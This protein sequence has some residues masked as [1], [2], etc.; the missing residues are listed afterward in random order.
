MPNMLKTLVISSCT[1]EKRFHPENQLVQDDFRDA[2][3]LRAREKK[4][5]EFLLPAGEMYTS[6]QHLRLMEGVAALR[7]AGI[8]VDLAIVSAGYGLIPETRKIAPYEVTFNSMKGPEIDEW[9]IRLGIHDSLVRTLA[10]YD[11]VFFLLG[12]KYLRAA[13]LR[14]YHPR[15][16]QT[17]LFFAS[18]ASRKS[19]P[20]GAGIASVELGNA[21]ARRFGYGLVGLKGELFRRLAV[22]ATQDGSLF[23]RLHDAPT[24]F[25]E[26]LD[27]VCLPAG[28]S[29]SA[30]SQPLLFELPEP[31]E[32]PKR[33]S[34]KPASPS[35]LIPHSEWAAN[36]L[37]HMKYFIP[38]WD[39]LV[40]PNYDF[41]TDTP[42][43]N[44]DPYRDD[45][46]A[47]EIYDRPNYDGILVSKVIVEA[48]KRK[49]TLMKQTD[50]QKGLR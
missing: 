38:E 31:V 47:H 5:A 42:T 16:D 15:Q 6:M 44:H 37:P 23:T 1:G 43:P 24:I 30:T 46:Y 21:D 10:A 22:V 32:K 4:L 41:L 7:G 34:R 29:A 26:T 48:N 14:D 3:T 13:A 25:A 2:R 19:L 33:K 36:Y 18:G 8:P 40:D 17:L 35:F 27:A 39:D 12:D 45:V 50:K 49:K 20:C 11:L 9:A 28:T